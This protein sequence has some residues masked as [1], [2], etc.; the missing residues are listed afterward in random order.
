MPPLPPQVG[1][2]FSTQPSPL[3]RLPVRPLPVFACRSIRR[4]CSNAPSSPLLRANRGA[5]ARESSGVAARA[6]TAS[7]RPGDP[8]V[9]S[10]LSCG[11][12][13]AALNRQRRPA[14][15]NPCQARQLEGWI[16]VSNGNTGSESATATRLGWR[17]ASESEPGSRRRPATLPSRPPLPSSSQILTQPAPEPAVIPGKMTPR[18]APGRPDKCRMR[19]RDAPR[20]RGP[21]G[22]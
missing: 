20:D 7:W 10:A 15:P 17:L 6:G 16:R 3:Q 8:P 12:W 1:S 13:W 14:T 21:G 18:G 9:P 11:L 5:C 19:P 4:G 2:P 22:L